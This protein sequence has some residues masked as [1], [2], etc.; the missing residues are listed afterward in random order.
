MGIQWYLLFPPLIELIH[1]VI[2]QTIADMLDSVACWIEHWNAKL[3]S[4]VSNLKVVVQFY[5]I[6]YQNDRCSNKH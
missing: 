4:L 5:F 2:N 3:A 6:F 1:E